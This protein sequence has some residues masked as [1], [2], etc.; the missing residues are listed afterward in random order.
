MFEQIN[1]LQPLSRKEFKAAVTPL[2]QRL[3]E[4]QRQ[5]HNADFPVIVLFAGVD[6]AGK[7]ETVNALNEWMDPRWITSRAYDAPTDEE[8][9]RP[10]YWRYWRDLPPR[11]QIALFQSTWYSQPLVQAVWR[12]ID[13]RLFDEKIQQIQSFERLLCD[14][15]ALIIKIWLQLDQKQQKKHFRKLEKDPLTRW[16]VTAQDWANWAQYKSFSKQASKMLEATHSARSPWLV[17]DGSQAE[18][19][20]IAVGTAVA[21]S[22]EKRLALAPA[23]DALEDLPQNQGRLAA[24]EQQMASAK[25]LSKK[26]YQERLDEL[27]AELAELHRK[28]VKQGRSTVLVFEGWDAAG[29]GG[30]IR[31]IIH[32]MQARHYQVVPIAAP[33]K[34]ELAQHY[35]WRFWQKVPRNGN[36][37]IYDRSWYGRVLVERVEGF[38]SEVEWRRAFREINEFEKQLTDAGSVVLKFWLHID[39]DEQLRRFNERKTIPHKAWKLTDE[40]WR[41][42]ERWDDYEVAVEQ[43][44]ASTSTENA[45]WALIAANQKTAGRLQI[46]E[47][48]C[49]ALR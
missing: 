2:R 27:Q 46:L 7:H 47:A 24:I 35:L 4:A 19:R 42:R 38:C 21:E 22:I 31:R 34:D 3:L 15:G 5:L 26:Q 28:A 39:K 25:T 16:Q 49:D 18:A 10:D 30:A 23:S 43:M 40:D 11:G 12:E 36:V 6:G 17:I 33:S 29:K 41:N 9:Q 48:V 14:D 13:E 32:P 44:L 20:S 8:A 1:T 37:R 45:P